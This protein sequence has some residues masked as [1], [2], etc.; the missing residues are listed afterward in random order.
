MKRRSARIDPARRRLLRFAA[1]GVGG[2]ALTPLLYRLLSGPVRGEDFPEWAASRYGPLSPATDRTTGLPL[3]KLPPGFSYFSAGWSGDPMHDGHPTPNR[4]DGMGVVRAT[5]DGTITLIRNH[6]RGAISADAALASRRGSALPVYDAAVVADGM[7]AGGGT[8]A[9]QFRQGKLID[10]RATLG[11]T[12][13]NCSGGATGYGSWLSCEEIIAR[14]SLAGARDHGYVFEVPTPELGP[15][16]ARPI[17]AMGLMRHE[18]AARDP[19]TGI[20]YLTEDNGADSGF[21]RFLPDDRAARIGALEAGGRLEMLKVVGR[22]NADLTEPEMGASFA[23]EWV[24][25]PEPDADP[26]RLACPGP[27]LPDCLG[28]GRSGPFLQGAERGGA[29]FRNCEGCF[30]HRGVTYL[31]DTSGGPGRC[32]VVW[33]YLDAAEAGGNQGRLTAIFVSPAEVVADKPDNLTLSPWGELLLCENGGGR[34][35]R[36]ELVFGTRLLGLNPVDGA[37]PLVENNVSIAAP[38]PERPWIAPGDYRRFEFAGVCC[39]PG[40][41]WLFVNLQTPGITFA[42]TGPWTRPPV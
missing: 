23:V 12:L 3:L 33:A 11:G 18:A 41:R 8:T 2:I 35:H 9:L 25:I 42:I 40:G 7:A 27:G 17:V 4:H 38:M 24:P 26:E 16:S 36:G 29:R 34:R 32:G 31:V 22:D 5:A 15:A 20:V 1:A 10:A 19:A 13:V 30:H 14:G 39:D 37:F 6:E 21:Y 28:A